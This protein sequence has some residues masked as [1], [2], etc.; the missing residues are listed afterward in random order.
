ML[1]RLGVMAL[2]VACVLAGTVRP[3]PAEDKDL[4]YEQLK[5]YKGL[6]ADYERRQ[7]EVRRVEQ[8]IRDLQDKQQRLL[9]RAEQVKASFLSL[10]R[11]QR[12][13][14]DK[15]KKERAYIK[16]LEQQA[17]ALN[18]E[19]WQ[20]QDQYANYQRQINALLAKQEKA[21]ARAKRLEGDEERMNADIQSAG[22]NYHSLHQDIL[23]LQKEIRQEKTHLTKIA[24]PLKEL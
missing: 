10:N 5:K 11:R 12:Q 13:I 15:A 19:F 2:C 21:Y 8:N 1:K 22:A 20:R 24:A 16:D 3:A 18:E 6:S 14:A 4:Y 7:A 23:D 9:K 17:T